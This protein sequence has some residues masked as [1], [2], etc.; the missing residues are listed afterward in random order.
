MAKNDKN[1]FMIAQKITR[2]IK[3]NLI[4]TL[5]PISVTISYNK[6]NCEVLRNSR[7]F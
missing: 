5:W 4:D 3:N 1:S 2:K 6:I 7:N